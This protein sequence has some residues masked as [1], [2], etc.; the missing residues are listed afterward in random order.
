MSYEPSV[1]SFSVSDKLK[2]LG[3]KLIKKEDLNEEV[4][5]ENSF[6]EFN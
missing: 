3:A 2:S 6:F 4:E 1:D 5:N